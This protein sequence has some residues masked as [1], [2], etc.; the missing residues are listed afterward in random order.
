M[1]AP[2][3]RDVRAVQS[4]TLPTDFNINSESVF[5]LLLPSLPS[6]LGVGVGVW[7]RT[8]RLNDYTETLVAKFAKRYVSLSPLSLYLGGFF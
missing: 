4:K 3:P 8:D 2:M 5:P 1:A 7:E 6:P